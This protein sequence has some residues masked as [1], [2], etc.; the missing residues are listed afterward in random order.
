MA[1]NIPTDIV[2]PTRSRASKARGGGDVYVESDFIGSPGHRIAWGDGKGGAG[3]NQPTIPRHLWLE[4]NFLQKLNEQ[5]RPEDRT[6]MIKALKTKDGFSYEEINQ[7]P[8][9][10]ILMNLLA[11]AVFEEG[12]STSPAGAGGGGGGGG[13]AA[14]VTTEAKDLLRGYKRAIA[15]AMAAASLD[16]MTDAQ[17]TQV[18]LMLIHAEQLTDDLKTGVLGGGR[19]KMRRRR[20]TRR[21]H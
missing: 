17:A 8:R 11:F 5:Q 14:T 9:G 12:G 20:K 6:S 1:A 3:E 19:R 2:N 7:M 15:A 10:E 21:R 16:G 4:H 18:E 13:V